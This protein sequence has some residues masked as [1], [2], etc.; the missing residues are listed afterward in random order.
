MQ[1]LQPS[2]DLHYE[3]VVRDLATGHFLKAL[4]ATTFAFAAHGLAYGDVGAAAASHGSSAH[5]GSII[6]NA[7]Q[8]FQKNQALQ[9]VVENRTSDPTSPV[10][11]QMWLRTDL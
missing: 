11:G 9:F 6:P 5:T 10:A 7:N 8:D 3:L 4:T 2:L 1:R